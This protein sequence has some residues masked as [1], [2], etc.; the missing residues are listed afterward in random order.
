MAVYLLVWQHLPS[1]RGADA[2]GDLAGAFFSEGF[3]DAAMRRACERLAPFSV[4]AVALLQQADVAHF[5][6]S[7]VRV[8]A[9]LHWVH[10]ACTSR[11]T[12]Y[13][14]HARR[15]HAAMVDAGV[16]EHFTG[17]LVAD[18]FTCYQRYGAARALCNAH[19][20]R[21]L[22]GITGQD[23]LGQVWA[24]A[25]T[26]VLTDANTACE[27]ARIQGRT[28]LETAE[29]EELARRYD[30][31]VAC[32][33]AANP[34]QAGVKKTFARQVADRIERRREDI[35]RFLHDL[36]VPFTDNQGEQDIRMVKVQMKT[37]GGWRTLDGANRWLL[38]RSY[39]STARK[40]GRNPLATLRDLFTGNPWH[41]PLTP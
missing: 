11:L 2:A 19:L 35:L 12:W 14:A 38:V 21:D 31:A 15:G 41:P 28:R 7:G 25:A 13:T 22:D 29:A 40:H 4:H 36:A 20:L 27:K 5:D 17:A 26:D 34:H 10:V 24:K 16:L 9:S 30:H 6:E 1:A 32:G 23:P 18:A 39:L 33:K 37:S 3:L 8:A